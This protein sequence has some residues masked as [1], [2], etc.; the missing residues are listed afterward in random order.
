MRIVVNQPIAITHSF[1]F[2]NCEK[3]LIKKVRVIEGRPEEPLAH[4]NELRITREYSS[5][6]YTNDLSKFL[7][8][9]AVLEEGYWVLYRNG[10]RIGLVEKETPK[11]LT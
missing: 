6:N 9:K 1:H 7:R 2:P 3:Q 8:N 5:S 4:I 10:R 11:E